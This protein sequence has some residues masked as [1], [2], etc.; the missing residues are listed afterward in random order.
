MNIHFKRKPATFLSIIIIGA[1]FG[2]I[3][4]R[5]YFSTALSPVSRLLTL[6]YQLPATVIAIDPVEDLQKQIDELDKLKKLSEDAT[7]PLEQQAG[8]LANRIKSAQSG[9]DQAKKNAGKLSNSIDQR[10]NQ[11]ADQIAVFSYRVSERYKRSQT[12]NSLMVFFAKDDLE[13]ITQDIA[14]KASAENQDKSIINGI[15]DDILKLETDKKKN[16]E[17]QKKLAALQVQLNEQKVFFD[18]EIQN[19]KKYQTELSGKIASLTAEQ[20]R[21]IASKAGT[22]TTSVGD[23][24]EGGDPKSLPSYNPGF[25]PAFAVFSF[26]A[27]HFKGM[28]QYG[29]KGRAQSGQNYEQI[30]KAYYGDVEVKDFS[31]PG[32]INTSVGSMPFEDQ[33]LKGIAE[34]PGNWPMEALK[35]Q[36]IAAR[37]Y[38]LT[39]L[40]WRVGNQSLSGSICVTEACQVYKSSKFQAGGAWHDA[41]NQTKG[42]VL[43]SK[44]TG[45]VFSTL[46]ASTAGGHLLSYSSNGHSVPGLWD[47]TSDWSNWT[48]GAYEKTGGSPWFYKAWY[49]TRS[50]DACGREHPWLRENEMADILN[51]WVVRKAGGGDADRVGP[52][53]PCWGGNAFSLDEM[54]DRANDKGG[55]YTSVSSV[56]VE[57]SSAGT[58][59]RVVFQTN[60]GEV[61]MS[62]SEFKE[63]FNLRA[64]GNISLKSNLYGIERK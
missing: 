18:K 57:H 62:G 43:V 34:M 13:N 56:K 4:M 39:Y 60:R 24:P 11:L 19:A 5:P 64:P 37:T 27:P 14:Y 44:S 36:A 3:A 42:K 21:I 59:S 17:D 41:V 58:T 29:A 1:L 23:V 26:G 8:S 50:G 7:K 47:S 25:S 61:S 20:Q 63:I 52:L 30:L 2:R 54:R 31:M 48:D 28:S 16:E 32:S 9:I 49:K 53:G 55:A 10:E 35:A 15:A 12:T 33:Y 45:D 46:Y 40:K 51:A 38:A 22:A 6:N